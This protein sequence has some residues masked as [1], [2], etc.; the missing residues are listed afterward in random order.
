M[1]SGEYDEK[2]TIL[3]TGNTDASMGEETAYAVKSE[4]VTFSASE[5]YCDGLSVFLTAEVNVEQGGLNNIPGRS[6]YL[7]GSWSVSGDQEEKSLL[8][9]TLEGKAVDDHT[10]IGMLKLDLDETGMESGKVDL[11]FSMIGYDD[12]NELDAE[13][14]SASHKIEGDW[15]LSL[16]F[17]VDTEAAKTIQVDIENNGYC[18]KN[19]FVSPYQVITYTDVPYTERKITQEDYEAI[20]KEKTG[21]TDDFGL[22]YEEYVEIMGKVYGDCSTII[23]NQDGEKLTPTEEFRGRSVNAVQ[24][25]E[26]SKLYVYIFDSFESWVE[27]EEE[28]M[29][30]KAAEQAVIS[31]EIDVK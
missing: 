11:K 20:A 21:G 12:I 5:V 19:V 25:M 17:T 29:K 14:I 7:G 18:L 27:M 4:G 30:S 9:H 23:F 24:G 6:I 22:T 13:D 16:P 28:G 1:F 10:F 3:D 8:N 2:A 26:I 31:A 15:E